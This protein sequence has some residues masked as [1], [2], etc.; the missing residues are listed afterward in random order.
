RRAVGNCEFLETEHPGHAIEL[1]R[2]ALQSGH[3]RIISVGGDGTHHEVVNGFFEEGSVASPINPQAVLA[4][5]AA[6]I[7]AD[8][9][10]EE[11]EGGEPIA[12]EFG[13]I[14]P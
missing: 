1:T 14:L 3:D 6:A 13:E 11:I 10:S 8:L 7:N 9:H 2:T 4:G 12:L 5:I